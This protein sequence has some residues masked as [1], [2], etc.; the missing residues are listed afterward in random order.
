MRAILAFA[1]AAATTLAAVPAVK[2]QE[3]INGY[4]TLGNGVVVSCQ[5]G[6]TMRRAGT[7]A[8]NQTAP[9]ATGAIRPKPPSSPVSRMVSDITECRPGY[10]W[11]QP[12]RGGGRLLPC[13]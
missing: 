4:K 8:A 2:A 3:C 10:Y 6:T 9:A 7:P 11:M 5:G 13:S 12:A 1:L